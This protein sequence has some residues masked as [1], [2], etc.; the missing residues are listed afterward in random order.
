[1]DADGNG[2]ITREE[3]V[4]FKLLEMGRV[5]TRELKELHRQ[6]DELDSEFCF[7]ER[8]DLKT[9]AQLRGMRIG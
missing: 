9:I 8:E 2:L 4:A 3:Y 6:F 7:L 5:D 1:M